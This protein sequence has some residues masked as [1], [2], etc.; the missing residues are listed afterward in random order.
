[1]TLGIEVIIYQIP[2]PRDEIS[3]ARDTEPWG[4][5]RYFDGAHRF[6]EVASQRWGV[7]AFIRPHHW[8]WWLC[9][10]LSLHIGLLSPALP[11]AEAQATKIHAELRDQETKR[12]CV[13]GAMFPSRRRMVTIR[14]DHEDQRKVHSIPF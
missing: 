8:R 13:G 9:I 10:L 6:Q 4:A 11:G 12:E 5:V 1:M 2:I 14:L 3:L 7:L